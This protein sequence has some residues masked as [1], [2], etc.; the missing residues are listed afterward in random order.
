MKIS[1]ESGELIQ[2][3]QEDIAEF[4]PDTKVMV[5]LRRY[6]EY[7]AKFIVN[8][9]FIVD[10]DPIRGDELGENE[11]LEI[12]TLGELLEALLEQDRII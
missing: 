12:K 2:E 6:P 10:D 4:G 7:N 11:T 8:Y 9:D 3:V 5:W 1:Y